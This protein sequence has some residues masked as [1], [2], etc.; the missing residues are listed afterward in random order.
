VQI[1]FIINASAGGGKGQAFH[2]LLM[3]K[4]QNEN[5]T[6]SCA[7]SRHSQEALQIAFAAQ[8]R[9][10]RFLVAC[11]G[12]GTIHGLLPALVNRPV[13]LGIIPLGTAN[14]LAR[15]W[16]IPKDPEEALELILQGR[17]GFVDIIATD[18]GAYIAGTAGVGFDAAVI[19]QARPWRPIFRGIPAFLLSML[20]QFFR[21]RLPWISLRSDDWHYRGFSWQVLLTKIPRYALLCKITSLF[22]VDNGR[23]EIF[24][25]PRLSRAHLLNY[26]LYF[27][28]YGLKMIPGVLHHSGMEAK[29]ESIPPAAIHGDGDLIGQTPMSFRVLVR[30]L[31][32]IMPI[33]G[34]SESGS[35]SVGSSERV[36]F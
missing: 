36:R 14:D 3:K 4:I 7:V 34:G 16:G 12:D 24:L 10:C 6:A 31:Q 22:P 23:M 8:E 32:V 35:K 13:V 20:E 29:I 21:F 18:S 28:R 27:F 26:I 25:I 2:S 30:A 11:G 15:N 19:T 5:L 17:P 33:S 1:Q 9:G